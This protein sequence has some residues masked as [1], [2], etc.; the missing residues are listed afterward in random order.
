M[1]KMVLNEQIYENIDNI[2]DEYKIIIKCLI[3]SNETNHK[4]I[5]AYEDFIKNE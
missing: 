3:D 4:N 1:L 2:L 5:H